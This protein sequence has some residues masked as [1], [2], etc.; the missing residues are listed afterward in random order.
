MS[1]YYPRKVDFQREGRRIPVLHRLSQPL[2]SSLCHFASQGRS[3]TT[4]TSKY[5]RVQCRRNWLPSGDTRSPFIRPG[6]HMHEVNSFPLTSFQSTG[7]S[8]D[9]FSVLLLIDSQLPLIHPRQ[10]HRF[11]TACI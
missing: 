10:T 5:I 2:A 3:R 6:E 9:Y 7:L 8:L 11:H 4:V 1:T